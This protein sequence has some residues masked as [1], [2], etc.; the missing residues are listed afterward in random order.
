[1]HVALV[2][3]N[4]FAT[5]SNDNG[6][7]VY[8][9]DGGHFHTSEAHTC[10]NAAENGG[11]YYGASGT[12]AYFSGAGTGGCRVAQFNDN[13]QFTGHKYYLGN[14]ANDGAGFYVASGGLLDITNHGMT[15]NTAVNNGG[16]IYNNN[17]MTI[18][19]GRFQFNTAGNSGG[20]IYNTGSANLA[21]YHNTLIDNEALGGPGGG[22]YNNSNSDT[23]LK[24]NSTI[25]YSS[26]ANSGGGGIHSLNSGT[27]D[28]NNLYQNV[29][30]NTNNLSLGPNSRIGDPGLKYPTSP[31][32]A[33]YSQNIDVADPDLLTWSNPIDF[34]GNKVHRPDGWVTH[35]GLHGKG[36]DIGAREFEKEFGCDIQPTNQGATVSPDDTIIYTVEIHNIGN[37]TD[38][39]TVTV[40]SQTQEWGVFE[41]GDFQLFTLDKDAYVS[42]VLTVTVP[43]HAD[44]GLSE[45][46]TLQC[47]SGSTGNQSFG[48]VQ[49]DVGLRNWILVEPEYITTANPSDVMTFTHWIT[50]DGNATDDFWLIPNVGPA[51]LSTASLVRIEEANG[52]VITSTTGSIINQS[53]TLDKGQVMTTSLQVV[54]LDTAAGGE[55]ANPGLTAQS[56][57]YPEFQGQVINQILIS[58]TTGTRYVAIGG[59]DE[60]NNCRIAEQPCATV[61]RAVDQATDG[62]AILV[63]AGQYTDHVTRTVGVDTLDQNLFINK[64]VTIRGGYHVD[65]IFTSVQPITNAVVLDAAGTQRGIYVADGVTATLSGLFIQNGVAAP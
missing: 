4:A 6:G 43:A 18:I 42:R 9:A 38:T 49:T 19:N 59:I 46:V 54:I 13:D 2:N 1:E 7:G 30:N 26:S 62:D 24:I 16:V 61:Q 23:S 15:Y 20:A 56:A 53:I 12:Y 60:G 65:D 8:N 45:I 55:I 34:D 47:E 50:N 22:V 63:A 36:S 10:A 32:L 58:Y 40:V 31:Y 48:S 44:Y 37:F 5:D 39:I 41:G 25:I 17:K 27:F 3:G 28:Y 33:Y 57:T 14:I 52:N 35:N 21:M 29:P 51:G 11:G 64:S